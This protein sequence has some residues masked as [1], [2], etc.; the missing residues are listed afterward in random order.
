VAFDKK[1]ITEKDIS[2]AYE[3]VKDFNMP[4][5]ILSKG[6]YSKKLTN[7]VDAFKKLSGLRTI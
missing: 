6:D 3:K 7:L 2:V 4:Y 1:R 5:T